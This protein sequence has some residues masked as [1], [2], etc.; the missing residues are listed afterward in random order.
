MLR[1]VHFLPWYCIPLQS[2]SRL[3]TR[4]LPARNSNTDRLP[5]GLRPFS[6]FMETRS[7][8][9]PGFPQPGL[10]NALRFSQPLDAF[11]RVRP[12]GLVSCRYR[13]WGLPY[14]AFPYAIAEF[15][16]GDSFPLAVYSSC[17]ARCCLRQ[18]SSYFRGTIP[19]NPTHNTSPLHHAA[20]SG[21]YI[22]VV[23]NPQPAA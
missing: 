17:T 21:L 19:I 11:L 5:K 13:S 16:F 7:N 1:Q 6:V 2:L 10:G 20:A 3:T 15:P 14:R 8:L 4:L 9:A 22:C 23:R 18:Q 12:P